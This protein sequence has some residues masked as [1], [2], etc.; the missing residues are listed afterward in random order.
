MVA[1]NTPTVTAR[2]RKPT[3]H[4]RLRMETAKKLRALGV[5]QR[6]AS[7][8]DEEGGQMKSEQKKGPAD[9]EKEKSNNVGGGD[10]D[11]EM[12]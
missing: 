7:K 1:D 6:K 8:K 9:K 2:R 4:M 10:E 12:Q 11:V 5:A 3:R